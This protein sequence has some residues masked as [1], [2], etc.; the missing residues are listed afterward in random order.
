MSE[1]WIDITQE[2]AKAE[3]QEWQEVIDRINYLGWKI[4]AQLFMGNIQLRVAAEVKDSEPPH[5][6]TVVYHTTTFN[7]YPKGKDWKVRQ[8]F[9]YLCHIQVH[10]A[11]E[12]FEYDGDFPFHAHRSPEFHKFE[13]PVFGS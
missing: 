8:I 11:S 7:H 12:F 5:R 6:M 9:R 4:T 13:Y 1:E 10:E 2:N 3:E